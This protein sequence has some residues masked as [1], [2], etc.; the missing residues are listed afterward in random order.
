MFNINSLILLTPE[1][2]FTDLHPLLYFSFT[3]TTIILSFSLSRLRQIFFSFYWP[4]S[5]SPCHCWFATPSF[6]CLLVSLVSLLCLSSLSNFFSSIALRFSLPL[7]SSPSPCCNCLLL[8]YSPTRDLLLLVSS[9]WQN[10]F[11]YPC[12]NCLFASSI[13][14][15]LFFLQFFYFSVSSSPHHDILPRILIPLILLVAIVDTLLRISS[16]PCGLL[17]LVSS[18]YQYHFPY[19]FFHWLIFVPIAFLFSWFLL[20]YLL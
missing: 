9:P 6:N 13:S 16:P 7:L 15:F 8:V 19:P 2:P 5:P 20:F 4:S 3:I 11:A 17:L 12:W 10:H 1:W 14:L 18:P